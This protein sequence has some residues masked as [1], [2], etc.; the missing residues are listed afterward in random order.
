MRINKQTILILI[1]SVS[2][3]VLPC[4]VTD[5]RPAQVTSQPSYSTRQ[6][7]DPLAKRFQETV[8][9]G[10]TAI[11]SA[12]ELSEKYASLSEQFTAIKQQNQDLTSKNQQL[13]EQIAS[14]ENQLK[15]TQQE[16]IEANDFLIEMR[17]ELN[18]WKNDVLGFRD[19]MRDAETAQLEALLK[20]L[21][22]LGGDV[23][24]SAKNNDIDTKVASLRASE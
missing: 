13:K 22:A 5:Q 3:S 2:V 15:Q 1:S 12:M 17:I 6:Q 23:K 20:I 10:P 7:N 24:E 9:Q 8:P 4:C 14:F 16:L 11:E 21:K 19:E 18:N